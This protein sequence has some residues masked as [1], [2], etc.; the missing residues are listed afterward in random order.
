M[1]KY[2]PTTIV[3]DFFEN[4]KEVVNFANKQKFLPNP[5][6]FF[7]G[8]RTQ[9]L[10]V[11]DESFFN[12]VLSKIVNI[13]FDFAVHEVYW[14]NVEMYFQ[15]IK[16]FSDDKQ[17]LINKGLIH[18]DG[19]IPLVG[20]IY[21]TEDAD[22][23]SGTSIFKAKKIYKNA[24]SQTKKF[25]QRKQNLYKKEKLKKNDL[26]DL[27]KLTKEIN[28]GFEESLR[29]NNIFNRFLSYNGSEFHGANNFMAKKD[30]ERLTLVFFINN[31][32]ATGYY[33]IQRLNNQALRFN[34]K[35]IK[36]DNKNKSRRKKSN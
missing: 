6:G 34:T 20:L 21:L 26:V 33:P 9:G 8:K 36:N 4:P 32:Q 3:D 30:E 2:F 12:S 11:I 27:E 5:K 16:P 18:Q 31:I 24:A 35:D 19:D 10:H 15:K 17:A 22:L 25:T 14:E 23:D 13:Y 1:I 28:Y 29:I 7:P